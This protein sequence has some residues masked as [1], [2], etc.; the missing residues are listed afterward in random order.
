M[1]RDD[2]DPSQPLSPDA[3]VAP[4][5]PAPHMPWIRVEGSY[6]I[7]ETGEPWTPIGQNDA[8]SWSDFGGLYRRRNVPAVE[9]H[10]RWLAAHGVTCLR[11]MMECAQSRHRYFER[12]MG[13]F[14]PNVVRLWD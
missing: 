10:M 9:G 1:R 2:A 8:I 13:R 3:T 5:K 4:R 12:P 7:T 6:F 11:F 14:V